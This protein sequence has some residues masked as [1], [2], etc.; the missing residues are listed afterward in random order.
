MRIQRNGEKW[1]LCG[2]N[3]PRIGGVG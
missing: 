1:T 3:S 2:M